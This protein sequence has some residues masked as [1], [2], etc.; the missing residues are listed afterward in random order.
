MD[1]D[2]IFIATNFDE[3]QHQNNDEKSLV[4]YEFLEIIVRLA[5]LK[6]KDKGTCNTVAESVEKLISDF[7]L[8]NNLEV[9]SWND[10]RVQK[11]WTLEIDLIFK[12]N[13]VG[14]K[15][16]FDHYAGSNRFFSMES[17]LI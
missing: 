15:K 7:I 8:P 13:F 17:A 12:A 16:M 4:R 10:F 14:I 1:I 3:N 9:M 6:F 2:Q 11:V 5:K